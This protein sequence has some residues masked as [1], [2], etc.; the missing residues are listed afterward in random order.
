[1][2]PTQTA[3]ASA[4][5]APKTLGW[6]AE[7]LLRFSARRTKTVLSE[8][9]QRGPLAVQRPFYPEG[10]ACHAYV[11]HPPGGVVGG[12]Q[13][14][15]QVSVDAEASALLTTPGATKF[16]RSNG[17]QAVQQ[18]F[19]HVT[20][21]LEW[22]PQENIFFP[23]ANSRLNT[24]INLDNCAA[25]IGWEIQC[26][27]RPVIAERFVPGYLHFSTQLY[28]E[29]KP[30]FI[31]HLHLR[32]QQDLRGTP[33][34]RNYP[35]MATLLAIPAHDRALQA[36]QQKALVA[37]RHCCGNLSLLKGQAGVTLL[38]N[39]LIIRYLGDST[40]EAHQLLRHSWQS[41]RPLITGR[42]A[43]PPRIWNT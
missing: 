28:R 32:S 9:H 35:V 3:V 23:K 37:A 39:V 29:N 14:T 7:L 31:D 1:M 11:L 8:R 18:Q 10:D 36:T 13:L 33:G 22:L 41:I 4:Q 19:F 5:I 26:L 42:S 20:G 2:K 17:Q 43:T 12:D 38:N 25:Y 16:Y 34:L 27:G 6:Q 40:A 30:L 21:T 15:T 24:Q